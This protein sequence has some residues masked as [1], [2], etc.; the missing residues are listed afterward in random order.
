MRH[1][2]GEF[3][4]LDTPNSWV[5]PFGRCIPLMSA[6]YVGAVKEYAVL[7]FFAAFGPRVH[8]IRIV[9]LLLSTIGLWGIYR[10][11]AEFC[12]IAT[13]GIAALILAINPAY[14]YMS[15][16]DNNAVGAAMAGL[17]L[18]CGCL[19]IYHRRESLRTAFLLGLAIGFSVWA[20]A[21]FVWI[22]AAGAISGIAVFRRRFLIPAAHWGTM[23]L[24]S[25]IGGLPF[26]VFQIL[27]KG[28]TWTAQGSLAIHTPWPT[29]LRERIY[30]FADVL[31]SDGEHRRMWAA[32]PLPDWQ[33][34]FF[35][36]VV[37]AACLVC[38]LSAVAKRSAGFSRAVALTFLL[39][40]ASLLISH[41]PIAEHHLVLLVPMAAVMVTLAFSLSGEFRVVGVAAV[42]LALIYIAPVIY[43]Q[44]GGIRGLHDTGGVGMWSNA[45]VP[46]ARYLD[47]DLHGERAFLLDW[48]FRYNLYVLSDGRVKSWEAYSGDSRNSDAEGRPWLNLIRDGGVFVV[49]GPENRAFPN[50]SAGFLHDLA[51]YR[52]TRRAHRVMQRN[53]QS[54]AEVIDVTA[55]S[56][57]QPDAAGL[58]DRIAMGDARFDDRLSG[59]YP[60]EEG[61][62]RWT[63][64]DFSVR[65]DFSRQDTDGVQLVMKLYIP[66]YSIQ[67]LGAVTLHASIGGHALPDATWSQAGSEVYRCELQ[68]GWMPSGPVQVNFSLSKALPPTTQYDR[69]LGIIVSE[70]SVEPF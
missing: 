56:V 66:D 3:E 55:N 50:P 70:V 38:L 4:L 43:W 24:G 11:V 28:A 1:S 18:A 21:N 69:E 20:R 32:P 23:A 29:L 25:L 13:G 34:W 54:Y 59:F 2:S 31:L 27:S 57:Q 42:G 14:L 36:I 10:I 6:S 49:S 17:G 41:L 58:V 37:M 48:G 52:P 16:F 46:L 51:L 30:W 64:R 45:D 35:P 39:T 65:F 15:V 47:R 61:R 9:S 68:S 62:F 5:C 26:L 7:P 22:L 8:F 53:G 19:A 67:K 60:P 44:A 12:G 63:R 33:L 40:G